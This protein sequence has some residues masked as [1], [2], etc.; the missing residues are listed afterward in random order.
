MQAILRL[1]REGTSE[2]LQAALADDRAGVAVYSRRV[3]GLRARA[4][5]GERFC[6]GQSDSCVRQRRGE[7]P[8]VR[9]SMQYQSDYSGLYLYSIQLAEHRHGQYADWF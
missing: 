4:R 2:K 7:L 1:A 8:S 5:P 6:R 9:R 3:L